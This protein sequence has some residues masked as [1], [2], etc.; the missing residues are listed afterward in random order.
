M[1]ELIKVLPQILRKC[2][3]CFAVDKARTNA[4]KNTTRN[5]ASIISSKEKS[6]FFI[7]KWRFESFYLGGVHVKDKRKVNK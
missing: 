5:F 1:Y 7:S 2:L 3:P 6:D 4:I